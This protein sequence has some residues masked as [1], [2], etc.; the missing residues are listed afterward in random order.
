MNPRIAKRADRRPILF[1]MGCFLIY[2]GYGFI[3]QTAKALGTRW[4]AMGAELL[5][6]VLAILLLSQLGWW[7]RAGFRAPHWRRLW[8][9]LPYL[10]YLGGGYRGV[11]T[12][13]SE[14][15][16]LALS[17]LL[18]G[19]QEE[20]WLRGIFLE[21][22]RGRY[23]ALRAVVISSL[24]FGLLHTANLFSGAGP[25]VV[26]TQ[27]LAT[28]LFGLVYAGIRIQ[29][30]SIWVPIGLH[31]ATDFLSFVGTSAG[32]TMEPAPPLVLAIMALLIAA[33]GIA[34]LWG[35]ERQKD[36]TA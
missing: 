30:G 27:V 7:R 21:T 31:A 10:L 34:L 4:G 19:F 28:L 35:V 22:F 12:S 32:Q 24:M 2:A 23:G 6:A 20:V 29:T 1:A 11:T 5:A 18:I 17:A 3:G 16:L 36:L 25:G 14:T 15:L 8:V 9:I 26:V 13:W 33:Y